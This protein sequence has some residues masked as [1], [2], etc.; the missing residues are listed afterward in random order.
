M[1]DW[2]TGRDQL[3]FIRGG[4]GHRSPYAV[5]AEGSTP[6]APAPNPADDHSPDWARNGRVAFVRRV[7]KNDD[8]CSM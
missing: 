4:R 7:G 1:A 5:S 2:S 8:I 3:M 6:G